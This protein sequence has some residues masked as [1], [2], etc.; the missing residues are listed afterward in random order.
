MNIIIIPQQGWNH[1]R[2]DR[3]NNDGSMFIRYISLSIYDDRGFR[4]YHE[5][6]K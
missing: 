2:G 5:L 4:I 3:L 6:L 1:E